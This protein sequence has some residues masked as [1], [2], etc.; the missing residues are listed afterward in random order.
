MAE[1]TSIKNKLMVYLVYL[2]LMTSLS[3]RGITNKNVRD[4]LIEASD[5]LKKASRDE[6]MN[7]GPILIRL[8]QVGVNQYKRLFPPRVP[9]EQIAKEFNDIYL[10]DKDIYSQ[11][12]EYG[13]LQEVMDC[14]KLIRIPDFPYHTR[15]GLGEHAGSASIED[16]FL[17]RDAF[18]MLSL[19]DE[20]HERMHAHFKEWKKTDKIKDSDL[21]HKVFVTA[22]QDIATYSRLC[23]LSFFSFVEAFV[24]SSAYDFVLRNKD[25]LTPKETEILHGHK[26]GRYLSLEYKIEKFPSI[27]SKNKKIAFVLS[28]H[29]QIK[30]PFKT[31]VEIIKQI[32]ESSVHYSPKKVPIW[33]KPDEW[34][35]IARKTSKN[36]VEIAILFWKAC[37]PERSLP[38]YLNH[39]DYKRHLEKAKERIRF[40]NKLLLSSQI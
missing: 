1:H 21:V 6:L 32:R 16:E 15:I 20:A 40:K 23:V 3:K 30:E 35:E 11:G 26:N 37:Y 14:S 2:Q 24:N 34:I 25:K 31:F 13:W 9:V 28:D 29:R 19:A 33:R 4:S 8:L 12:L 18:F 39:L 17:L 38:V 22:N 27:I 7:K 5:F 10:K 36:C